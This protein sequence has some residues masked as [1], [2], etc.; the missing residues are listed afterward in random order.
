M[1]WYGGKN[2]KR[3]ELLSYVGDPQQCAGAR[4]CI[5][6]DGKA[7]GVRAV[8]VD[9]G[10]GFRFTVL[11]GRGMDIPYAF[12]KEK[13][14]GFVSGT[15]MTAPGY[16]DEAGLEW[17]RTF[18]AGLLTTCGIANAGSPSVDR[19]KPFGLHGRLANAGAENVSVDQDWDGDEYVI[20]LK[21]TMREVEA[22]VE[23]LTLTR[24][25]ETRMGAKGFRLRDVVV[26]RDS[27][28]SRSCSSTISTTG[29]PSFHPPPAWSAPSGRAFRETT[30]LERTGAWPSA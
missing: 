5:L 2:W 12:F 29:F 16:Y 27:S 10:S 8:E 23:N 19:G 14:I 11:P 1:A 26:D 20:Q 7:D 22:M 15:G 24:R 13:A 17:R 25:I 4:S 6:S 21:G 3:A 18:Y 9:T 30:R 28:L